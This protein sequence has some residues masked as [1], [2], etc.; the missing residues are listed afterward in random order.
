MMALMV[1]KPPV[2]EP[3]YYGRGECPRCGYE[4]EGRWW[5][6]ATNRERDILA[7]VAQGFSNKM[8]AAELTI[9][10]TTVKNHLTHV[11]RKTG[12]RDRTGAVMMALDKGWI[13]KVEP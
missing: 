1:E 8:I 2:V 4:R 6:R 3:V 7:L 9:S 13:K 10:P 11:M 12:N 5:S